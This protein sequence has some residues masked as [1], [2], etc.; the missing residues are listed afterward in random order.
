MAHALLEH[1]TCT[2]THDG[3]GHT[4]AELASRFDQ[5]ALAAVLA[6]VPAAKGNISSTHEDHLQTSNLTE[7][8]GTSDDMQ[9]GVPEA[10]PGS[11]EAGPNLGELQPHGQAAGMPVGMQAEIQAHPAD[12][13][14]Y[15][16]ELQPAEDK[17]ESI[18]HGSPKVEQL[19]Q[20]EAAK[21]TET[22]GDNPNMEGVIKDGFSAEL[23][24]NLLQGDPETSVD[25]KTQAPDEGMQHGGP[26]GAKY[27]RSRALPLAAALGNHQEVE[28]L[29]HAGCNVEE[30]DAGGFTPLYLAACGEPACL[31]LSASKCSSC[32]K[33][34][35]W[36]C[37]GRCSE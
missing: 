11:T 37:I 34:Q 27:A 22:L 16:S 23:S 20:P 13:L 30:R 10:M 18:Q 21:A 9:Q 3:N 35:L 2:A 12:V 7:E 24:D 26:D 19:P 5:D 6:S 4:A 33:D 31:P 8:A 29:L 32:R 14:G 15:A 36:Q 1:G 28:R 17:P 25:L